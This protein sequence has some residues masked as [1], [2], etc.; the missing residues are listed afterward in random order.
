MNN[1]RGKI[2]TLLLQRNL[3]LKATQGSGRRDIYKAFGVSNVP[4]KCFHNI[5][6]HGIT[7]TNE[8]LLPGHWACMGLHASK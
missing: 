8:S 4:K 5:V 7:R 2:I 6:P 1:V 3:P